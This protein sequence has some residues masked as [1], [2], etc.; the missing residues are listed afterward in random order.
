MNQPQNIPS[1]NRRDFIA[2]TATA[3]AA[4]AAGAA[5]RLSAQARGERPPAPD[6][7]TV[8]HPRDRI[9]VG[10]IIDD[11]TCLVNLN[12]FAMPQF[13]DAWQGRN[14]SYHRAW[15]TWP[16][17]I[18]D[19]FVRRF[20]EWALDRG[21]KGKYSIVPYPACVGRVDRFLPGWTQAELADSL[22]L[23]RELITPNW[24]IHPEMVTH[25][26]VID[27]H[28]GQP[29]P[30]CSLRYMEN[31]EWSAGISVDKMT[32][33]LAY[34]LQILK[35][36]GLTCEGLTTP[37]GFGSRA[38]PQLAQGTLDAVR[39]VFGAE[40]PHYFRDAYSSGKQSVAP[41]VELASGLDGDDPR[42]VVS[43]VACTGDWTG[44][45]NCV[46]PGGVDRF[47]TPDLQ[48]GRVVEI[49]NRNEPALMLCHWT[50]VY[51]NGQEL[52]FTI[53]RE[54][55][56]RLRAGYAD[57]I[58][59]MKLA[60]VARYWAA[61]ELTRITNVPG[62]FELRAPFACPAFTV[63]WTAKAN[64]RP[65][66]LEAG[67]QRAPLRETTHKKDLAPGC[68]WRDQDRVLA[69]FDLPQGP[70]RLRLTA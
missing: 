50:G 45:W 25:T 67:G 24:D 70:S 8:L 22:R 3:T 27:L 13:N 21:V 43:I 47:I 9:P 46:S 2:R 17:E 4:L 23:V 34:A 52:G 62:G 51:W 44:G 55:E 37:G 69:C 11:S 48:S 56:R 29:Y 6:G 59:W 7:L 54:V 35:N 33:Y 49:L 18:P 28:T 65:P 60:E 66:V 10:I 58:L 14:A 1:L 31:W 20:A 30:E 40:I 68:W 12:R 5:P 53:W 63:A 26:R 64:A 16:A 42:C 41:R 61:R 57:R 38:R 36:A 32:A 19:A 39:S 15:K